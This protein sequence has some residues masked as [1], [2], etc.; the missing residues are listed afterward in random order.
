[1]VAVARIPAFVAGQAIRIKRRHNEEQRLKA[2][3][4]REKSSDKVFVCEHVCTS[5]RM[6][7]KVGAFS[8]DPIPETIITVC[9]VSEPDACARTVCINQHRCPTGTMS[10]SRGASSSPQPSCSDHAVLVLPC[11]TLPSIRKSQCCASGFNPYHGL[12]NLH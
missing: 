4:G 9:G 3:R 5:K 6:L 2:A 10:A 8:K 11:R 1:V 12:G 7:K